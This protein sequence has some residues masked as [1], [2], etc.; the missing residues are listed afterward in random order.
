MSNAIHTKSNFDEKIS[1]AKLIQNSLHSG[2]IY[3]VD[4]I[5]PEVNGLISFLKFYNLINN[6]K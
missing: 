2:S 5:E 6:T 3:T 1:L 4:S